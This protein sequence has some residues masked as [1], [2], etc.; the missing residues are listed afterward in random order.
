VRI[1]PGK[2]HEIEVALLDPA[3]EL[4]GLPSLLVGPQVVPL[5]E[6]ERLFHLSISVECRGRAAI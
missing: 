4:V 5:D 6:C 1:R 2:A 3:L